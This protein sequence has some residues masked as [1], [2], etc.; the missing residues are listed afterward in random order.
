MYSPSGM[1]ARNRTQR[2][3]DRTRMHMQQVGNQFGIFGMRER[4][5]GHAG[6]TM[7]ERAHRIEQMGEAGRTVVERR[8]AV[9][10]TAGRVAD[11]H[12][13]AGIGQ[14]AHQLEMALHLGRD[15]DQSDR[16]DFAEPLDFAQC[17]RMNIVGLCAELAGIDIRSFEMHAEHARGAGTRRTASVADRLQRCIEIRQR[18]GH[19]RRQEAGRA[20]PR[21]HAGD[22]VDRVGG[23]HDVATAAAMHMQID[24]AGQDVI[25]LACCRIGL[26]AV[27]PRDRRVELD[28]AVDP[29][30]R[31]QD[32]ASQ[33]AR[34]SVRRHRRNSATKS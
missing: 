11:L 21:M 12:A 16:R 6:R 4:R 32:M 9:F 3:A 25:A 8:D 27:D 20:V 5:T 18:R 10:V 26:H 1:P 30:A 17:R 33:C 31:C 24:E 14:H 2:G 23:V 13:H 7:M 34:R 19:R 15:R 28:G 29:A 22:R